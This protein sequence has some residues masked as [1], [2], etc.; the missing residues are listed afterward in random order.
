MSNVGGYGK[1][2]LFGEH[3]VVYGLPALVFA[4][5]Q[6]TH[7]VAKIISGPSRVVDQRCFADNSL[8]CSAEKLNHFLSAIINFLGITQSLEV[9]L[10][11]DLVVMSGG[12]GSSAAAAV[13]TARAINKTCNLNLDDNAISMAAL[14]AEK[15]A[16]GNPSGIDNTAA[17]FGGFFIFEKGKDL[18]FF[19]SRADLHFVVIDSGMRSQTSGAVVAVQRYRARRSECFARLCADYEKLFSLGVQAVEQGNLTALSMCM[20]MNHELLKELGVSNADL[21]AIIKKTLTAGALSV[22]VTGA[23][24]GGALVALTKNK[25]QQHEVAT[26]LQAQNFFVM[27]VTLSMPLQNTQQPQAS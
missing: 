10:S 1:I 9:T 21:E 23:G 19:G 14:Q 17:T 3:F 8:K 18:H 11:G 22:K 16:H 24:A 12:T 25:Q 13:A 20:T 26:A 2:I 7:A 5:P 6:Q 15:I 27:P 4:L